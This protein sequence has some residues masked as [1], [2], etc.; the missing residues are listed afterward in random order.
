MKTNLLRTVLVLSL[1]LP[2]AAAPLPVS[3]EPVPVAECISLLMPGE[4][5]A[6]EVSRSLFTAPEEALNLEEPAATEPCPVTFASL[7]GDLCELDRDYVDEPDLL[8]WAREAAV[9]PR[10]TVGM[11]A[12]LESTSTPEPTVASLAVLAGACLLGRRRRP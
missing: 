11:V 8:T 12:L 6:V 9:P 10:P 1:S 3:T 7:A 4:E 2:V 5:N